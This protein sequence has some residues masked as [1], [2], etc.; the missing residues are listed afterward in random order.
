MFQHVNS[1]LD[2]TIFEEIETEI[3]KLPR[4]ADFARLHADQACR[5]CSFFCQACVCQCRT[6]VQLTSSSV[7]D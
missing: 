4:A 5:Q 1:T 7:L 2:H 3:I 6:A